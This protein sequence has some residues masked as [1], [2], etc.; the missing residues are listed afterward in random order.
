MAVQINL[1]DV[2]FYYLNID[3]RTDRRQ[4]IEQQLRGF[5]HE[6]VD[7]TPDP[8][9]G[10]RKNHPFVL[11]PLGH[12]KV[13]ERAVRGMG[14]T[15]EPFVLCEDDITWRNGLPKDGPVLVTAPAHAD[16]VYLGISRAACRADAKG[17]SYEIIR[18]RTADFP[19]LQR[20]YNM[21]SAHAVL[22]LSFRHVLAYAQSMIESCASCVPCDCLSSQLFT[23]HE[24]FAYGEPMFYQ[25]KAV[26]GQEWETNIAWTD[27]GTVTDQ[28]EARNCHK[29][30]S[31]T[32]MTMPLP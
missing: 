14:K 3:A 2:P 13:I 24:V 7:G 10:E 11:A 16:A 12:A 5:I 27:D 15:F 18:E 20:I 8:R 21:L 9:L 29:A 28:V 31:W 32:A 26:G 25:D 6:R 30:H 4:H 17:Y 19:H 1:R 22:F 23:R